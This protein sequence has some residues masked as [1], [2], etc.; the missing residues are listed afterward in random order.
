MLALVTDGLGVGDT[1]AMEAGYGLHVRI[2]SVPGKGDELE[3][4]LRE[5]AGALE[6]D[7]GCLLYLVSRSPGPSET[8]FVT[9]LWTSKQAHD[10]S[11]ED[12]RTR[13]AIARG[14][15]M[16]ASF[17]SEELRPVG[18]KTGTRGQPSG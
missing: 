6:E 8:V 14:R 2:D 7:D 5:A 13:A 18:G 3:K 17:G 10:A 12:E 9:E 1:A 16:I 15:P 4:L 11:L